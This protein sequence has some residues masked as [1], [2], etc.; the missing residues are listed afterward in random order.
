[1]DHRVVLFFYPLS[2]FRSSPQPF[3]AEVSV[4]AIDGLSLPWL[5]IAAGD[6]CLLEWTSLGRDEVQSIISS[7]I[8]LRDSPYHFQE[9]QQDPFGIIQRI[10][11]LDMA[12]SNH[13]VVDR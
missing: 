4:L 11:M 1:M 10:G 6:S 8:G 13:D 12:W 5:R 7:R 9:K 3:G 2:L